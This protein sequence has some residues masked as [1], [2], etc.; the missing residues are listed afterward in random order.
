MT[1]TTMTGCAVCGSAEA[2]RP[3][4]AGS[5]VEC[6]RC[7]FIWTAGEPARWR[8]CTARAISVATLTRTTSSPQHAGSRQAAGSA[9]CCA[10][11]RVSSLVEAG[12][13]GGFF[14]EAAVRAGIDAAGVELSPEMAAYARDQLGLPVWQGRF[15]AAPLEAPVQAVCAFHVLE[16]VEDPNAFVRTAWKLLDPGGLLAVEVPNIASAAAK[17][18]GPDWPGL[19][20]RYH[21]W[22]FSPT[23]CAGWSTATASRW[24]V[25][26]T[27]VFRY[28]MPARF[29]LRHARHLLAP[30]VRNIRSIRLTHRSRGDLL[31][32]D[33][34][35]PHRASS[36]ADGVGLTIH[37]DAARAPVRCAVCGAGEADPCSTT[38]SEPAGSAPSPGP[39][40]IPRPRRALPQRLL[41]GRGLRG[42]LPAGSPGVRGRPTAALAAAQRTGGHAARS[43]R[44]RRLLPGCR[45]PCRHRRRGRR[46]SASAAAF[47]RDQLGVPVRVGN[48]ETAT[49]RTVRRRVRLP[50]PRARRRPGAPSSSRPWPRPPPAD[51]S[52]SRYPTSPPPRSPG[53]APPGRTSSPL[54]TAGTSPRTPCAGWST[55][56]VPGDHGGHG[57]LPALLAAVGPVAPRPEAAGR[58]RRRQRGRFGEAPA[59]R[60]R[61]PVVRPS[62]PARHEGAR[63]V[64]A[65]GQ[66]EHPRGDPALPGVAASDREPGSATRSWRS[67]TALATARPTCSPP[68]LGCG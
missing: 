58:R 29:R 18:L 47:A 39:P 26:D 31:R 65:A 24:S 20:P 2:S 63:A 21:R 50:R 54:T 62:R 38:C 13:A 35:E 57:L 1:T 60:R 51:G 42:L 67:T 34:P 64:G 11:E 61:D 9:G 16:H 22:H 12:C 46:V 45:S 66:L 8:T 48:F 5:L 36:V 53:S 4:L 7:D 59:P 27:A 6:G 10:P 14:V 37:L 25:Q 23:R 3:L 52:P 19:Q 41:R 43:R 30:D 49:S 55:A 33:R 32:T 17:R 68:T 15:E 56:R 44:R 40:H 28:Y